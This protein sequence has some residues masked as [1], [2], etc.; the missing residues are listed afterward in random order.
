[1]NAIT[2]YF[3]K[4]AIHFDFHTMPGCNDVGTEFNGREFAATLHKAKVEYINIFA[5]CNLGFCYYPT[6]IGTVYPGL[7]FD[8]MGEIIHAC[9]KAGIRVAVYFN[10]GLS[11]E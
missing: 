6:R 1:M 11:H 9:K 2:N 3:P 7:K 4:R 8:L 5:K 10:A